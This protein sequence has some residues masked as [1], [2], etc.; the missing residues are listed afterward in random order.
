MLSF[1]SLL[2]PVAIKFFDIYLSRL[3]DNKEA[4]EAFQVFQRQ[5]DAYRSKRVYESAKGQRARLNEEPK[6]TDVSTSDK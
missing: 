6:Q 3:K 2:V 5:L 1:L 4:W